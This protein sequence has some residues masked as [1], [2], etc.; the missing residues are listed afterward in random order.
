MG[1]DRAS[2]RTAGTVV[3]GLV[4]AL[5]LLWIGGEMRYR[6]CVDAAEARFPAVAVSA[7]FGK[8]TGPTKVSFV[9]ERARA[10]DDCSRFF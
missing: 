4:I 10:L 1:T 7:F 2:L 3:L 9:K 5:S 8:Q 6:N